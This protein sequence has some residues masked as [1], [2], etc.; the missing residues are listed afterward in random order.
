MYLLKVA[1]DSYDEIDRMFIPDF[2]T[3]LEFYTDPE[4]FSKKST[5]TKEEV[6]RKKEQIMKAKRKREILNQKKKVKEG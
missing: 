2:R 4:S 6:Q 1:F 3:H 5:S